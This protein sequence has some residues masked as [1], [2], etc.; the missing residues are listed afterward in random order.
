MLSEYFIRYL[1]ELINGDIDNLYSHKKG[2][3]IVHFFNQYFDYN[4][5]YGQGFHSRWLY[6][7]NKIVEIVNKGN[8]D[9][10][11]NIILDK[12]FIMSDLRIS[13]MQAIERENLIVKKINEQASHENY[14]LIKINNI[15]NFKKI[16]DDLQLIGGGGFANIFLQKS[17]GLVVKKLKEEFLLDKGIKS[18][19]KREFEITNS[20]SDLNVIKV[21]SFNEEN[22][23]YT[24]ERAEK[25]LEEY[26]NENEILENQKLNCIHQILFVMEEVHN[27]KIIHR[28]I[29]PNNV[30]IISG[31]LLLSDFGLGKDLKMFTS[32]MTINTNALGQYSYCAPEQFML[33]REGNFRSDVYSLGRIINFIFTKNPLNSTHFLRSVTEK[34]TNENPM[35]RY[36]NAG[37]LYNAVKKGIEYHNDKNSLINIKDSIKKKKFNS[38]VE[39]YIYELNSEILLDE[40][41]NTTNFKYSLLD[42]MS[43]DNKHA[44]Y[45]IEKINKNYQGYY[46]KFEE[47]DLLADI[48]YEI[49][50]G[51]YEFPVKE[52]AA[53]ILNYVAKAVNRFYAQD[54]IEKVV[55]KGIDPFLEEILRK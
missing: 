45:V 42:F 18:R 48:A 15:Y 40:I 49:I 35:I 8:I 50:I 27:R 51:D 31:K 22:Y 30:L 37:E 5:K 55:N 23:S 33:L 7:Y 36:S 4:D 19:F 11:F 29:S 52:S 2:S 46:K 20:L 16:D 32:H 1:A 6:T 17:T 53:E 3:K 44:S 47:N 43:I 13:E 12:T 34:A 24:M 54:L 25:T 21:F 28:D 38:Y 39:Q 14:K 10:F 9:N 26:I 41:I